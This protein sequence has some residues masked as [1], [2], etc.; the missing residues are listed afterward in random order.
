MAQDFSVESYRVFNTGTETSIR[1]L[2]VLNDSVVW[3]S[4]SGSIFGFT[5][6]G[7]NSW[8]VDTLRADSMNLDLR[9]L[10]LPDEHTVIT[11]NAGTPAY[12][13][14]SDDYGVTWK[15]VYERD[16]PE[17]FLDCLRFSDSRNGIVLGDPV[18]DCFQIL[19]TYDGGDTW[20]EAAC[21]TVP[22]ALGGEACFAS[23]NSS[24]VVKGKLIW[25]GTGSLHSRVFASADGGLRWK[26]VDAPVMEGQELTGIFSIDFYDALHGVAAGGN[27]DDKTS[28]TLTVAVT[29]DGG[30]TWEMIDEENAPPFVSCV[31]YQPAGNGKTILAACLPGIYFSVDGGQHWNRLKNES[32]K[33]INESF[34]TFRFSPS[35]HTAWFAGASGK[36]ALVR[37]TQN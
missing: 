18:L 15:T 10:A 32:G 21:A 36:L 13:F 6:D 34:F 19:L 30:K 12:I 14:K 11:G 16:D 23:S 7:G 37:F 26:A 4:G 25:F 9:L 8:V 1:A 22:P 27:Y 31:Q 17:I 20:K 35:G 5:N 3:F 28:S 33:N 24:C 29:E 2:E